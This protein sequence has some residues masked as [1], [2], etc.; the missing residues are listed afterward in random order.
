M[1]WRTYKQTGSKPAVDSCW[2]PREV[3]MT[4]VHYSELSADVSSGMV[5]PGENDGPSAEWAP[6]SL[7]EKLTCRKADIDQ[8]LGR[9]RP[10]EEKAI[11]LYYCEGYES[12]RAVSYAMGCSH[13]MAWRLVQSGVG[14]VAEYL[15]GTKTAREEAQ[16]ALFS[17]S[18]RKSCYKKPPKSTLCVVDEHETAGGTEHPA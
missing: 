15:C 13:M 1:R 3:V 16:K 10:E 9:L 4:L 14:T 18:G 7:L 8:A 12:I 17:R 6:G 11:R 2:R 5:V